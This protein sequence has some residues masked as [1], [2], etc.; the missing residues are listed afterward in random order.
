[1][2]V[3]FFRASCFRIRRTYGDPVTHK[4]HRWWT[5][6]TYVFDCW[7]L[8]LFEN[9]YYLVWY[10]NSQVGHR[11]NEPVNTTYIVKIYYGISCLDSYRTNQKY[12]YI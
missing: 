5:V 1:V 9:I 7:T 11:F 8:K 3:R 6:Q 4:R 2:T 10:Y 12:L